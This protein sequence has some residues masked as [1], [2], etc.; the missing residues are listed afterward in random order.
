MIRAYAKVYV[1]LLF[2]HRESD[3]TEE[4]KLVMNNMRT[5]IEDLII[6]YPLIELKMIVNKEKK[7]YGSL[8][9]YSIETIKSAINHY[10]DSE[11]I[12]LRNEIITESCRGMYDVSITLGNF[13]TNHT[14]DEL[15]YKIERGLIREGLEIF[16]INVSQ[17]DE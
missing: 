7:P 12:K 14:N 6:N 2:I 9:D 5:D 1:L 17:H 4:R 8:V 16:N 3:G 10:Y 13:S 15:I 11:Y